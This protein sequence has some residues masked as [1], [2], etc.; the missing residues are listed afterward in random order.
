MFAANILTDHMMQPLQTLI[1]TAILATSSNAIAWWG[2]FDNDDYYH[3]GYR[4][5]SAWDSPW[6][7]NRWNNNRWNSNRWDNN[8]WNRWD[9]NVIGDMMSDVMGDMSGDMDVEIKFKIRGRGKGRGDGRGYGNSN[10][11]WHHNYDSYHRYHD[12]NYYGYSNYPGVRYPGYGYSQ[13]RY[14]PYNYNYPPAR[15]ASPY[16]S[17]SSAAVPTD[18]SQKAQMNQNQSAQPTDQ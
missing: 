18:R 10:N 7:N 15:A 1:T 5:N 11:Y 14:Q 17:N 8:N 16:G 2:P 12:G 9:N 4:N 13:D 6:N 3:D